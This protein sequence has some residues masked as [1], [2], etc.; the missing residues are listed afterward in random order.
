MSVYLLGVTSWSDNW[1]KRNQSEAV[2]NLIKIGIL[3]SDFHVNSYDLFIWIRWWVSDDPIPICLL[4]DILLWAGFE[5]VVSHCLNWPTTEG[6][7][8]TFIRTRFVIGRFR[9]CEQTISSLAKSK[10]LKPG[11]SDIEFYLYFNLIDKN[12]I[13]VLQMDKL[14]EQS[15]I[16]NRGGDF[17]TI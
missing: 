8:A 6:D 11:K 17:V 2:T 1:P 4:E 10:L 3:S 15:G 14:R 13:S 9:Q 7:C 5:I 16:N 12:S